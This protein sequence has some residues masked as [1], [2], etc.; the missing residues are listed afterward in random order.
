MVSVVVDVVRYVSAFG[1]RRV[2]AFGGEHWFIPRRLAVRGGARFNT[3][4]NET[5]AVTAGASV[6]VR[7][8]L[9]VDG[10]FVLGGN[11]DEQG[12]GVAAR[13]SF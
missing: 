13:V 11:A 3:V 12:W 8:G 9:Y 6:G 5:Q 10:H 7:T 1:E 4:G 2:I